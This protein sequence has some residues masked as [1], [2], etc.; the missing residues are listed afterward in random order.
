MDDLTNE[1]KLILDECRVLLKEHRQ[2]CEESERTGINNDNETDELY[3]EIL[4]SHS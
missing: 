4:A 2:P 1:Q 3:K